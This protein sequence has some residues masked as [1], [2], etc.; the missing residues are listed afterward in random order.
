MAYTL[1]WPSTGLEP[2]R[3]GREACGVPGLERVLDCPRGWA[4]SMD[5]H[6]LAKPSAM[7]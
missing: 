7:S 2:L 5:R 4:E 3:G 6:K 1:A